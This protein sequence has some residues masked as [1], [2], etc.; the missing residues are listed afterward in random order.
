MYN[1]V[2]KNLINNEITLIKEQSYHN[3]KNLIHIFTDIPKQNIPKFQ[4]HTHVECILTSIS[5][6]IEY[7]KLYITKI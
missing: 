2:Y 5:D 3:T 1:I 6:E 4:Y 7:A